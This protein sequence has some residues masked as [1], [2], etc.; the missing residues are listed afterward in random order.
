V[1]LLKHR[2]LEPGA[3]PPEEQFH[4]LPHYLLD[5]SWAEGGNFDKKEELVKNGYVQK[6][7]RSVSWVA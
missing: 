2:D 4:T 1:T 3:A 7:E 5:E 6:L